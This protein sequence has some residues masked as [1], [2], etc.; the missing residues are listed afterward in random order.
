MIQWPLGCVSWG[1]AGTILSSV[2]PTAHSVVGIKDDPGGRLCLDA[3]ARVC[4][5]LLEGNC[6]CR[7]GP[8][9][10]GL[11]RYNVVLCQPPPVPAASGCIA[12]YIALRSAPTIPCLTSRGTS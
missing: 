3:S 9:A 12:Q 4:F 7:D 11:A 10:H 5:A 8:C 6:R 2:L 1:A